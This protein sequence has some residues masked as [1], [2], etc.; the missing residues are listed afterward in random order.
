[1]LTAVWMAPPK[2][3]ITGTTR[4]ATRATTALPARRSAGDVARLTHAGYPD[5]DLGNTAGGNWGNYTR[6]YPA[7]IY[8]IF[9]RVARGNGGGVTDAGKVSVVTSDIT[10]SGQT[11]Q[12]WANTIHHPRALAELRLAP[13]INSGGTPAR[14]CGRWNR[15]DP[16]LHI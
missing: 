13:V 8:N 14:F 16:A 2:W 11:T 9:V 15:Q 10:Q 5:Y 4:A 1:M 12:D 3:I 7:G 6:T